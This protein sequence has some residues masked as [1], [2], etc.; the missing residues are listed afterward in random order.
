MNA[1]SCRH[2][3][4]N[5]GWDR[6]ANSHLN[7]KIRSVASSISITICGGA[8][9]GDGAGTG[10]VSHH[11]PAAKSESSYTLL[12]SSNEYKNEDQKANYFR[13]FFDTKTVK[14]EEEE[15]EMLSIQE[16]KRVRTVLSHSLH[17]TDTNKLS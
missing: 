9:D 15:E 13:K 16:N 5:R 14:K 6:V 3:S 4:S 17:P 7:F 1:I 10:S 11:L 2:R 8:G 12:E